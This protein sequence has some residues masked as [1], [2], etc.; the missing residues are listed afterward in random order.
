MS[1]S[2]GNPRGPEQRQQRGP[3]QGKG[4]P[5]RGWRGS[6]LPWHAWCPLAAWCARPASHVYQLGNEPW[7]NASACRSLNC[8]YLHM[9]DCDPASVAHVVINM[10][11][12]ALWRNVQAYVDLLGGRLIK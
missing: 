10:N 7:G 11:L 5:R 12:A 6:L 9:P 2:R 1:R 4:G 3:G 8:Y